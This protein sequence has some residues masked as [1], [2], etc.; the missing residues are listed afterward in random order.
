MRISFAIVFILVLSSCTKSIENTS[1]L[2]DA[3]L[4]ATTKHGDWNNAL[5]IKS[6]FNL[7]TIIGDNT[8]SDVEKIKSIQMPFQ[9]KTETF[10][11]DT[12]SGIIITE[13]RQ[14]RNGL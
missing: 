12:L 4:K 6:E 3:N 8:T 13:K 10:T 11:N 7:K 9:Q 2:I 5:G 1:D 14:L